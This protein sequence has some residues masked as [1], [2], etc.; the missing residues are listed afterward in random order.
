MAKVGYIFLAEAYESIESDRAWME[1]FGCVRIVEEKTEDEKLRP[2]WK[3]L[4]MSLERGDELV[5]SKFSNALRGTRELSFFLELCRIKVI[6]IISINDKIDS[7]D[8]VFP[9]MKTSDFLDMIGSLPAEVATL[10]KASTHI[11][12]L[13]TVKTKTKATKSR[14]ERETTIVNMYNGGHSI[15]DIWTVS[16]FKSRSSIFR[17]L[18]KYGIALNRGPHSGPIK[19][20]SERRNPIIKEDK[21]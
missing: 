2:E 18:K 13:R 7:K 5:L 10:R 14:Q 19:K 20:W 17:I 15:D 12:R 6:R 16:G 3:A 21:Q 8:E 9:A 11:M 4:L 1:K